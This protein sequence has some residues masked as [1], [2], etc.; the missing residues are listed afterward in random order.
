TGDEPDSSGAGNGAVGGA[1]ITTTSDTSTDGTNP[2]PDSNDDPTD[3]NTPTPVSPTFTPSI[4]LAKSSSITS[5]DADSD[6]GTEG[7]YEV[8]FTFNLANLGNIDL[9]NIKLTDILAGASPKFGTLESSNLVAN[10]DAGEYQLVSLSATGVNLNSSFDG[11]STSDTDVL[12]ISAGVGTSTLDVGASASIT[13]VIRVY[14]A[15]TY[16]NTAT[17]TADGANGSSVSDVSDSGTD[18][19]GTGGDGDN[20]PTEANE[21]DP[22]PV[23]ISS[24]NLKLEKFQIICDDADCVGENVAVNSVKTD[25]NIKTVDASNGSLKTNFI[26]YTITA[27]NTGT[28]AVTAWVFDPIPSPTKLVASA[29]T[30]TGLLCSSSTLSSVPDPVSAAAALASFKASFSACSGFGSLSAATWVAM[31]YSSASNI[32]GGATETM[33]FVVQVP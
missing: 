22:T 30:T 14:D 3:N 33:R 11:D 21:D 10:L 9:E 28:G 23:V 12:A 24:S 32:A 16:S 19:K 6:A 15:G 7:P 1:G 17:V 5:F 29:Q 18:P 20:D 2:D 26:A 31:D 8:T 13:M 27:Q 25:L 4:G